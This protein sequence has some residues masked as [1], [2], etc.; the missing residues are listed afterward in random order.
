MAFTLQAFSF[1]CVCLYD[2]SVTNGLFRQCRSHTGTS[3]LLICV[4][5]F[6]WVHKC[7]I[8]LCRSQR[9]LG[10]F[11]GYRVGQKSGS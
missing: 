8:Q 9:R 7:S 1:C 10:D 2:S 5:M 11:S 6:L 4:R 3:G